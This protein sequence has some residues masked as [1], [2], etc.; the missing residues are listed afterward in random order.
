MEICEEQLVMI[1]YQEVKWV[2]KM[3]VIVLRILWSNQLKGNNWKMFKYKIE[4]SEY[5]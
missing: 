1:F 2:I 3:L 4:M 5:V